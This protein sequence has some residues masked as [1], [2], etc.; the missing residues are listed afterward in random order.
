V[1]D[2][3]VTVRAVVYSRPAQ[4]AALG[5]HA[6]PGKILSGPGAIGS[7][8]P[9]PLKNYLSKLIKCSEVCFLINADENFTFFFVPLF[10]ILNLFS[11]CRKYT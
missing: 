11:S 8:M 1:F 7:T 9:V 6:A 10:I 3:V 5:L 2:H 4:Y